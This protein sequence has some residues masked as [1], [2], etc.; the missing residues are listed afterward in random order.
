MLGGVV[1]LLDGVAASE[2]H[3][4]C[5]LAWTRQPLIQLALSV[6]HI[7]TSIA[8]HGVKSTESVLLAIC[9]PF[10][11]AETAH[12]AVLVSARLKAEGLTPERPTNSPFQCSAECVGRFYQADAAKLSEARS[13]SNCQIAIPRCQIVENGPI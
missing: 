13:T 7:D 12:A 5:A 8:G 10:T 9:A 4:P 3:V 2:W 6:L 11:E 1:G